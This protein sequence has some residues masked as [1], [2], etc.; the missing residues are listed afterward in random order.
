MSPFL[1]VTLVYALQS[2]RMQHRAFPSNIN[3]SSFSIYLFKNFNV[4]VIVYRQSVLLT[5]VSTQHLVDLKSSLFCK[6]FPCGVFKCLWGCLTSKTYAWSWLLNTQKAT[7][8]MLSFP[9]HP[10]WLINLWANISDTRLWLHRQILLEN[11]LLVLVS[12]E[13]KNSLY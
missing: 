7:K 12:L 3:F 1:F 5:D 8:L 4:F 9:Q 2:H 10:C 13:T 11:S 6:G